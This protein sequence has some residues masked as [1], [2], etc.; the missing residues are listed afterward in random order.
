MQANLSA[1]ACMHVHAHT[2]TRAH[3]HAHTHTHK[4]TLKHTYTLHTHIHTFSRMFHSE[5]KNDMILTVLKSAS[6]HVYEILYC[7]SWSVIDIRVCVSIGQ[8]LSDSEFLTTASSP[9]KGHI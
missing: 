9:S 5:H 3:T 4:H 2:H 1:C 6:V 7:V 8:S